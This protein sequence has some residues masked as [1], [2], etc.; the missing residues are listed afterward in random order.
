MLNCIQTCVEVIG[1]KKAL[2]SFLTVTKSV[3]TVN[4][5]E[6]TMDRAKYLKDFYVQV[7]Q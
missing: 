2:L 5:N 1:K 4:V 3:Y 6:T 7:G